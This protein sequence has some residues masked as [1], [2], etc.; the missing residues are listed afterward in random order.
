MISE[1]LH[2]HKLPQSL[3]MV[4]MIESGFNPRTTSHAGAAGLWQF[5]PVPGRGYGLHRDHWIDERRN[6]EKSTEAALRFLK[7]LYQRFGS[8]ELAL[9]AYNCGDGGLVL[10]IRK[11][12]TNDY[13][14]LSRYEAGLPWD[15][16]LYVPK[17]LA[18]AV[19]ANNRGA[20]GFDQITPDP[21][22]PVA[23]V[24]VPSSMTL[25]Q[26][27]VAAGVSK[28]LLEQLNP[29]L[30]RGRTPP[31]KSWLRVPKSAEQRFYAT[32][33]GIKGELARYKPYVVRLG[34]SL[35]EVARTHG[36]S[37]G[38]LR[39]VNGIEPAAELRPGLTILVPARPV[40]RQRS[41]AEEEAGK[42]E[43]VALVPL[44]ADKP[45][46]V[47]G[48]RRVFYRTVMGDSLEEIARYLGVRTGELAGWNSLDE[49]AR[50]VSGMVLQAFV[51][52][53]FD[54]SKVVLLDP[55]R[56]KLMTA[57]SEEFYSAYE[58]RRGRKRIIYQIREGDTL[59]SVARRHGLT[60]G[61][62]MRIN[63]VGR[64]TTLK[65]G[66]TLVLYVD[67]A[68]LRPRRPPAGSGK[69]KVAESGDGEP[70]APVA[71]DEKTVPAAAAPTEEATAGSAAEETG[72]ESET[73]PE[74]E[75]ST[76]GATGAD[77]ESTPADRGT[78]ESARR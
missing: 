40:S 75:T 6:P 61:D 67:I 64:K 39:S 60:V 48:R 38:S 71:T 17:I 63:Q 7:S 58:E 26:A 33:P 10:A 36:T 37:A 22:I 19:V 55:R 56:V 32:L 31:G 25:A 34:D 5:M 65:P 51:S 49:R 78:G 43:D 77:H 27:A 28:D 16:V 52:K 4:A 3:M 20:F 11:Y 23:Q 62:V 41:E 18:A 2:R 57:G 68:R 24:S 76:E 42:E 73:R 13:W 53:R 47:P 8:W 35:V 46:S 30:Q 59:S 45:D 74:R 44:P 66:A 69:A 21:E 14:K 9:A 70:A 1:A 15:T 29:E 50:L 12:N 54:S 72:G